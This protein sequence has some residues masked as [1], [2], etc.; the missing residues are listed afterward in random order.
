[1]VFFV[2]LGRGIGGGLAVNGRVYHGAT[3]TA[4]EIGHMIVTE[5]GPRCSCGGIG[6]LEA[7]A[8]AYA[9]VRT[10]IGLSVEYPE[11]EAAIRRIT[12]G[13]AERIT[14]EQ[15]FKLAAE[16][17]QVA[18]RVVHGVHTY[19]GLA[20]ANI[21]QLVNP[22]MIILGGPGANAGELLIA[23]LSERIHE[24]CLP[25]ASQSLRV[26]QSSLG[27]EAPLVG[28]VTLALQDL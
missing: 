28:A 13:R 8:S 27:S 17:D 1:M 5:D 11:T 2:G 22:S 23:P 24:L 21:V 20:L 14:V 15:I 18:Q 6:H 3:G 26:A 16:G 12:D 10:M 25:E 4:G 7:I 19:L 9:I